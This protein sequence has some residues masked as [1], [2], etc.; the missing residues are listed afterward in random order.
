MASE[1]IGQD[2]LYYHSK[3][4]SPIWPSM[5]QQVHRCNMFLVGLLALMLL[6]SVGSVTTGSTDVLLD[7]QLD[8][9]GYVSA[10]TQ[11]NHGKSSGALMGNNSVTECFEV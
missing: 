7:G 6:L 1:S 9:A 8:N 5:A 11:P 4:L 10:A 3:C 2:G